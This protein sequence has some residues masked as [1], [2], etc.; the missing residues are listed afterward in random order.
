LLPVLPH[1]Q[2]PLKDIET[3]RSLMLA[4]YSEL[5]QHKATLS[6]IADVSLNS[7]QWPSPHLAFTVSETVRGRRPNGTAGLFADELLT[8]SLDVGADG[9]IREFTAAGRL[10]HTERLERARRDV[11]AHRGWNDTQVLHRLV[12]DG[13]QATPIQ[14]TAPNDFAAARVRDLEGILGAMTIRAVDFK[15]RVYPPDMAPITRLEWLVI[16]EMSGRGVEPARYLLT[17]EPFGGKLIA[18]SALGES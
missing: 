16:A 6:V 5:R 12:A 8:A 14:V 18:M 1:A 3:A 17:Y 13:A 15:I 7:P 2:G 4:A 11:D 10:A 9:R